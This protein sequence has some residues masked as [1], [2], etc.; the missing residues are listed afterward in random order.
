MHA[1]PRHHPA[2]ALAPAKPP[3]GS[4]KLGFSP[5]G[6]ASHAAPDPGPSG[7]TASHRWGSGSHARLDR[8]QSPRRPTFALVRQPVPAEFACEPRSAVRGCPRC[9]FRPSLAVPEGRGCLGPPRPARRRHRGGRPLA[10]PSRL[11][12]DPDPRPTRGSV[13]A[14]P[15][16]WRGPGLGGPDD[17]HEGNGVAAFCPACAVLPATA[18]EQRP[19]S[20]L[21]APPPFR[22]RLLPVDRVLATGRAGEGSLPS[23]R[24]SLSLT[25]N[26]GLKAA[27][28]R[29]SQSPARGQ[30]LVDGIPC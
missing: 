14:V 2:G 1:G 23:C 11:R 29:Q 9:G 18:P 15:S 20:V 21:P 25:G 27:H 30:N 10:G 16:P 26:D 24:S 5:G 12:P 8:T 22:G 17:R 19:D 4:R 7:R 28:R 3:P 6:P 13:D